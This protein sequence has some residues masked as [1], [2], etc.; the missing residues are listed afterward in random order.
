MAL[1]DLS[2][3]LHPPAI[4]RVGGSAGACSW[5]GALVIQ[6][7]LAKHGELHMR[8]PTKKKYNYCERL[9]S[10]DA[11]CQQHDINYSKASSLGDKHRVDNLMLQPISQIPYMKRPWGTTAVQGLMKAK[12][13]K[14]GKSR[15]NKKT[16]KKN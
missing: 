4:P 15:Q 10:D 13:S 12:G 8:T 9:A 14:N 6:K 2:R 7:Q 1:D 5:V 11:I 3:V 16:G